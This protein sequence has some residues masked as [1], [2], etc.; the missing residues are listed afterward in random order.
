V[1]HAIG[2][3]AAGIGGER[4]GDVH[5]DQHEGCQ[6]QRQPPFGSAQHQEGFAEAG[7][8][9]YGADTDDRPVSGGESAEVFPGDRVDSAGCLRSFRLRDA[10]QQACHSEGGGNRRHPED[11]LEVVG[12]QEHQA[13]GEQRAEEGADRV[14]GLPQS[15]GG[16][17]DFRRCDVCDQ[18]IS[19]R[20]ADAFADA[21]H[22]PCGDQ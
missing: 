9:E 16:A 10:E 8:R 13:H 17:P 11:R 7:E 2:E 4:V 12:P 20:A 21:V 1:I 22:Q 3:L 15:E 5:A 18:R 14:E 19:R 6:R